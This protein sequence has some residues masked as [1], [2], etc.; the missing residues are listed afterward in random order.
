MPRLLREP[1]ES[2][3]RGARGVEDVMTD[4]NHILYM[5]SVL[6]FLAGCG[7][8]FMVGFQTSQHVALERGY[9]AGRADERKLVHDLIEDI[10]RGARR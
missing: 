8:G 9:R 7:V 10:N 3:G 5:C 4:I 2:V 6:S 1:A